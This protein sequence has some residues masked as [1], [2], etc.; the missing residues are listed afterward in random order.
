MKSKHDY[1]A[2]ISKENPDLTPEQLELG[3]HLHDVKKARHYSALLGACTD[4]ASVVNKVLIPLYIID[5]VDKQKTRNERFLDLLVSMA[6]FEK[7]GNGH[8]A[9]YYVKQ[10]LDTPPV[11]ADRAQ[12]KK[13]LK[14]KMWRSELQYP[15]QMVVQLQILVRDPNDVSNLLEFLLASGAIIVQA[16]PQPDVP[17][18]V[19]LLTASLA[20]MQSVA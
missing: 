17:P 18:P 4:Y 10:L 11:E 5:E 14:W 15:N 2:E 3:W 1:I 16:E 13:L 12:F 9:V 20:F 6:C 8:A 19:R 7:P